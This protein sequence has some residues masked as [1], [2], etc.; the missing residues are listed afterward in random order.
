MTLIDPS[1]T[2]QPRRRRRRTATVSPAATPPAATRSLGARIVRGTLSAIC[3]LAVAGFAGAYVDQH[4]GDAL[5]H[6]PGSA[7]S[8][9]LS[10][11]GMVAAVLTF[12]VVI[13]LHRAGA[14]ALLGALPLFVAWLG[15]LG[16]DGGAAGDVGWWL[17]LL[18]GVGI[19]GLV[20][21]LR[22]SRE[23]RRKK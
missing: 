3:L 9:G 17:G 16:F 1:T 10:I 4:H 12:T 2:T 19:G 22:R 15:Y 8:P 21:G 20:L 18:A 7:T 11:A 5:G 14:L 23:N 6:L 13:A